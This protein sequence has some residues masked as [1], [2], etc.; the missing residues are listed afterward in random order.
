MSHRRQRPLPRPGTKCHRPRRQARPRRTTTVPQGRRHL[1]PPIRLP[2]PDRQLRRPPIAGEA[3]H[4][5]APL[6]PGDPHR[7]A[8]PRDRPVHRRFRPDTVQ[9][10][11]GASGSVS[12]IAATVER[13]SALTL[14]RASARRLVKRSRPACACSTVTSSGIVRHQRCAAVRLAFPPH[15]CGSLAAADTPS[16]TPTSA[17]RPRRRRQAPGR[18]R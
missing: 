14:T 13:P 18:R 3:V 6:G 10:E 17:W 4:L 5:P 2:I 9:Q 11:P 1:H 16:P 7:A 8:Q 15:P 12:A